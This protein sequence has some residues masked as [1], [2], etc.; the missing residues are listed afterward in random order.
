VAG[1]LAQER[2]H[3]GEVTRWQRVEPP[4]DLPSTLD[5]GAEVARRSAALP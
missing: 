3:G 2:T 4:E 1:Q 5:L